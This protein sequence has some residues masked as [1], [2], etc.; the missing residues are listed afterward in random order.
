VN[1]V[2]RHG[3]CTAFAPGE[4]LPPNPVGNTLR[5]AR[6][7]NDVELTWTAPQAD[8]SH[9]PARFYPVWRS[10][11]PQGG[12]AETGDP[13]AT[14]WRDPGAGVAASGTAFYVVGA[15]NAAGGSGEAA[16]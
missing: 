5:A 14:S 9:D 1:L 7:G 11:A 13:T 4:T 3:V 10:A 8:A 12:F 15:R 16:P 2:W 6:R